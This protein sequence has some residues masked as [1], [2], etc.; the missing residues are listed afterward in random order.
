MRLAAAIGVLAVVFAATVVTE[1]PPN[2]SGTWVLNPDKT[3]ALLATRSGATI[4]APTNGAVSADGSVS[5]AM[6]LPAAGRQEQ[7]ITHTLTSLTIE[8]SLPSE[9][10]KYIF[11]LDGTASVNG[12]GRSTL[13]TTTRWEVDK[14]V[15]EGTQITT[16]DRG[17]ISN[18]FKEVRSIDNDGAMVVETMRQFDGG[19]QSTA[20]QVLV[21][22][23]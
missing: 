18:T 3:A 16:T 5:G 7:T 11:K 22:R 1:A 19:A 8:R 15:T 23:K 14:L 9:R 20:L 10:Q 6:A 21:K 13:T 2:F 12:N 17:P 4:A